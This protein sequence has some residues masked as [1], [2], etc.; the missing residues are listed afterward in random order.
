[1]TTL[2]MELLHILDGRPCRFLSTA[3]LRNITLFVMWQYGIHVCPVHLRLYLIT[4]ISMT[5][6]VIILCNFSLLILYFALPSIQHF[7]IDF[8][9]SRVLLSC[10][11]IFLLHIDFWKLNGFKNVGL[12]R[13]ICLIKFCLF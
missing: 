10:T 12:C 1:M 4:I 9:L 2:D 7:V 11:P 6:M 13:N 5:F 3:S 8:I